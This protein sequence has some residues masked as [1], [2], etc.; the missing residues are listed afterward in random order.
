MDLRGRPRWVAR[1]ASQR[2]RDA[3]WPIILASVAAALSWFVAHTVAIGKALVALL[4]PSTVALGVIVLVTMGAA[5]AAGVGF[6]GE[7][8]MFANQAAA[9]AILVVTLH[10]HGSGGER[11]IDAIVGGAIAFVLGVVLFPAEP[12]SMLRDRQL[13]VPARA[14]STAH[15]N[16]RIAPRRWRLRAAVD[17]ESGRTTQLD[18]LA[19]A[20]L[21]TV[22]SAATGIQGTTPITRELASQITALAD[23]VERLAGTPGPWP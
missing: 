5:V 10:R 8:M 14:Q 11:V 17:A 4:G 21:G 19:N 18:L 13:D 16:V 3:W 7:G 22:R 9:S 20:V 15:A 12:L 2:L 23:A 6:F 1:S